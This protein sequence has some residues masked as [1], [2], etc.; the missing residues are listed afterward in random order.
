MS[1][2]PCYR[3]LLEKFVH[4]LKDANYPIDK[5]KGSRTPVFIGQFTNDHLITFHRSKVE[6]ETNLLG[7]NLGLYN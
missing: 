7:P 2:D 6:N 5:I 1:M 3:I 4:L